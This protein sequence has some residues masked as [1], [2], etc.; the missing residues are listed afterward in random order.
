MTAGDID[1]EPGSHYKWIALSNTTLGLLMAT[2]NSSIV[3][4][5]LPDIFRGIDI[6]PLAPG[7]T[8]YLLWMIMG[9][10][11]VTAV[12]V[13][14]FGR[15]GDMYGRVKMYNL[16][17]A[18]FTVASVLL[19]VTWQTGDAA[20]L[21]LIGWRVVQGVGGAFIM[22]NSSAIL[23]DAFPVHQRGTAMG[24]NGVAAIAGSFLGLVLGGLLGPANWH[25]VFLVSVPV[26]IFGTIWAYLKLRDN[27][28]R[29]RA[30]MD[31]W[32]N[33]TFA[34]GLIALLVGI[35]YGIQPYGDSVMGW[36]SPL[37]LSCIIGGVIV[38][39]GF[40]VIEA[41]VANPLFALSLFKIRAFTLGNTAN[42]LA[43]LGRGGLQFIL[44]IW[45]Q[46]IWLPQHGYSFEDTP[47]WAGIYM[48]PLTVGFLV[49]APLS[50]LLSDRYGARWFATGGMLLS[51]VSFLLLELLPI[52]FGYVP[53]ALIL[54]LNGVGMGLFSS[55]NRAD[56]MNSL[57]ANARGAGAGMTATFQNSAMVLSIGFFF[58]LMIAGLSQ[59]L[60]A[61]MEA[62]LVQNGVPAANA[63]QIAGLPPV[64]VLFASFLGFNPIQQLLGPVL[65]SIPADQASFLTGRSFFPQL[66]S[67]PFA[68]GLAAAFWFAI[69]ACVVAAVASWFTGRRTVATVEGP[70]AAVE[71]TRET[72]GGEL[73]AVAAGGG[74][75]PSELVTNDFDTKSVGTARGPA[76]PAAGELLGA[77]RTASGS[78]VVDGVVTVTD[79][80]GRQV[81][82]VSAESSGRYA[83]RG[84]APG[85]YTVV[86]SSPGLRPD[87]AAITL[88]GSGAEHDFALDGHGT[89]SGTVRSGTARVPLVDAVVMATDAAGRVVGT[90]RTAHEGTYE[91]RGLPLG[92]VTITASLPGHLPTATALTIAPDTV[93][94]L[95]LTLD[96]SIGGLE[97]VVSA[98][99]GTAFAGATVTASDIHG[100]VVAMATT[101][102]AGAYTLTGLVPGRYTV[103]ATSHAPAAVQVELPPG[104]PAR[105]DL[106]LGAP[107]AD[108]PAHA[109]RSDPLP[110]ER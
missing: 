77:M 110:S 63:S 23:T 49:S 3:L 81:G 4:I 19:A 80:S 8:S 37:V 70:L 32:G 85:T 6:D 65:S 53:F 88:N 97:G 42:L 18:I 67:G 40:G 62:G 64:A 38:L 27:G 25:L 14:G 74:N 12:L 87:V 5:A 46:G 47:L 92:P 21:W 28:Q 22:A 35:T 17:F 84:L 103:V 24:I 68:D 108:R 99:D 33:I 57:P 107:A 100:D 1:K 9:F 10:L 30:R 105:I 89:V 52:D 75:G 104:A 56:V 66:I 96:A 90:T 45:L 48:L 29:V 94:A 79:Q 91:L 58:S 11:V 72:V 39:I 69:A 36:G 71:L 2:I 61:V 78:G 31:W 50:G 95:D 73:A 101:D 13:V 102:A 34:V 16:G 43:S 76:G 20:A 60:P 86:A 15:L 83:L 51:A 93:E 82:R 109:L 7:N 44:I 54:L 55:P 106:R 41:K 59:H 98:P 26:G